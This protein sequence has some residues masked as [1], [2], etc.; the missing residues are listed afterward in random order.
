VI[1]QSTALMIKKVLEARGYPGTNAIASFSCLMLNITLNIIL[2]PVYEVKGA[3][4]ATSITYTIYFFVQANSLKKKFGIRKRD[5]ILVNLEEVK[6]LY[7]TI[8]ANKF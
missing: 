1:L 8:F 2:I 4:V 5:F 3:A 6:G 7:N